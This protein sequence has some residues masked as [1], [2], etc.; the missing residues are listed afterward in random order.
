MHP[1]P[2]FQGGVSALL[3][4]RCL[5]AAH[6]SCAVSSPAESERVIGFAAVD[7]S[8]LLSGFQL[9]CG[10]YNI[11]D[12][13][14]QC[15]GQIKVAVSPLQSVASLREERQARARPHSSAV[16]VLPARG[17]RGWTSPGAEGSHSAPVDQCA[18]KPPH[19]LGILLQ[20]SMVAAGLCQHSTSARSSASPWLHSGC[21]GCFF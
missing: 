10:W 14:G 5:C 3:E 6:G 9:V 1:R 2:C 17:V 13:S 4:E 19:S 16:R 18:Q 12:F 20:V 15:R 7:L 11:T 8:P 21:L